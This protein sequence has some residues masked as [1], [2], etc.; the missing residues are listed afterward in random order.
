MNKR[1]FSLEVMALI[2]F[3]VPFILLISLVCH[4]EI[5]RHQTGV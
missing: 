2:F 3:P 1:I 5:F 4:I